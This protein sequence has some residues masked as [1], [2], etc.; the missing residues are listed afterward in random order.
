MKYHPGIYEPFTSF[1]YIVLEIK[2]KGKIPLILIA[3]YRPPWTRINTFIEEF[4]M[5]N[6]CLPTHGKLL[7]MGDFNIHVNNKTD[8]QVNN[9]L[10]CLNDQMLQNHIFVPT[11]R[12]SNNTLDLILDSYCDSIVEN[13]DV[14]LLLSTP[15]FS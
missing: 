3:M 8:L 9:F 14:L 11:Y 15:P 1:E 2:I 4:T 10:N 6:N 12:N 13:V 5:L 7:F